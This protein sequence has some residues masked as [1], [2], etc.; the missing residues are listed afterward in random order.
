MRRWYLERRR[1]RD[2]DRMT[3]VLNALVAGPAF[4][5]ELVEV[6]DIGW[7]HIYF[8]LMELERIGKIESRWVQWQ[9]EDRRRLYKIKTP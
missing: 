3:L 7:R 1:R 2:N 5:A 8:V 6:T 9:G 4:A